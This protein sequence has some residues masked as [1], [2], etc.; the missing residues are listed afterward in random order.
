MAAPTV[1]AVTA[2]SSYVNIAT[3]DVSSP[4]AT[5]VD[6]LLLAVVLTNA[7]ATV[8]T[9][10]IQSGWTHIVTGANS[11]EPGI[12]I[13]VARRVATVSGTQ[14]YQPY[15]S[16]VS[17]HD[18]IVTMLAIT[19][20]TFNTTTPIDASDG[21]GT[22]SANPPDPPSI[23]TT[24]IDTLVVVCGGWIGFNEGGSSITEPTNYSLQ[25]E[26]YD[27]TEQ[28][29]LNVCTRSLGSAGV[30]NPGAYTD[31]LDATDTAA[32]TL[33]V[34]PSVFGFTGWGVPI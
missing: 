6:D 32:I 12:R 33:A 17:Q 1:R 9:H 25:T 22:D 28:Q 23:T 27:L 8:P 29:G 10:T 5:Q 14:Q 16:G 34:T 4:S 19:K 20:G 21:V 3:P 26:H 31:D 13:S 30:E 2:A 15:T 18:G 7:S 11:A 24:V